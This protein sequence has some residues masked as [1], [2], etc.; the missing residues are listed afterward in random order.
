MSGALMMIRRM[1]AVA[2]AAALCSSPL[3][4]LDVITRKSDGKKVSG[5][6]TDMSK[7]EITLKKNLGGD[8]T[9]PANDV[10]AI[11]WDGAS[12]D[13]RLGY[14]DE[15]GEKFE[16]ALNHYNKAKTDSKSTSENLKA[17]F[18]YVIARV[19]ARQAMADSSKQP[20]A[21]KMLQAAQKLRPE[22]FR[23]YD[24]VVLLGKLQL[25]MGDFDSARGTFDLLS[26]APWP[27]YKLAARIAAG[28]I[29]VAEREAGRSR[30]GI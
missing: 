15:N 24:S 27:D 19:N 4:A 3:F 25:A 30:E 26:K 5:S 12:P 10:A 23:Y 7:N 14:S 13:L 18:D 16:S 6:I 28:R 22:H 21:I 17:E 1:L 2:V 11:D 9:I 20:D 29:L 8:E